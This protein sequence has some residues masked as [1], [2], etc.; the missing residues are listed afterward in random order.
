MSG[1]TESGPQIGWPQIT[2]ET[3]RKTDGTT[4][5]RAKGPNVD[6]RVYGTWKVDDQDRFCR[7]LRNTRG[8]KVQG[9]AFYVVL[10]GTH[11]AALA[12]GG[13]AQVYRR[14]IKR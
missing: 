11:Y 13:P 8:E 12:D 7:D 14:E 1:A 10:D 5:G 4:T 6:V 2:F 3:T 9:C